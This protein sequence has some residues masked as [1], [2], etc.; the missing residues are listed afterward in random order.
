MV[1]FCSSLSRSHIEVEV[2]QVRASD[3]VVHGSICNPDRTIITWV[4]GDIAWLQRDECDASSCLERVRLMIFATSIM[5]RSDPPALKTALKT[6][7]DL[8]KSSVDAM[9]YHHLCCNYLSL[10]TRQIIC[11]IVYKNYTCA[12]KSSYMYQAAGTVGSLDD[13]QKS[14]YSNQSVNLPR[15]KCSMRL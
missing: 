5:T 2:T 14:L 6:E 1:F 13:T 15:R 10:Y 11:I 3:G 9:Y 8:N 7:V 12:K 4:G